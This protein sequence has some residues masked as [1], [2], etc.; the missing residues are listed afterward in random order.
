LYEFVWNEYCDWYLEFTKSTL[1]GGDEAAKAATRH[2]LLSVLET[3]LR[4]L[5]PVMPFI[6][7]EIWQRIRPLLG[8]SGETI[9]LQP[10]P[11][12]GEGSSRLDEAIEQ[13]INWLKDVI[14]GV[15]RIRSELNIS[16]GKALDIWFQGGTE[17]DRA[18]LQRHQAVFTQLA[19]AAS[20]QWVDAATDTSQC[21]VA[22]LADLKI[23]VPLAGLIDVAA[24]LSRLR[25]QLDAENRHVNTCKGKLANKR[26]VENAPAEVVEQERQRLLEHETNLVNLNEQLE[27]LQA[28]Q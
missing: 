22:L 12:T 8:I 18:R 21:A 7:E 3:T 4:C 13:D 19:R 15:R 10:W 24:E 1:Q 16:P 28:M 26:F 6:S 23:L 5:H 14:Q 11:H 20:C 25:K 17:T 2:T 9:M 27:K